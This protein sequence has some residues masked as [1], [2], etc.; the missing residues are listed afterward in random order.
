MTRR[1]GLTNDYVE[2]LCKKL[3]GSNYFL[4]VLP[5]DYLEKKSKLLFSK[6]EKNKAFAIIINL[7]PSYHSGSHFVTITYKNHHLILFDSFALPYQDPNIWT[8]IIIMFR[9]Y[10][11]EINS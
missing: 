5:C 8:F 9:E 1:L 7:S 4:G 2:T 10:K 6:V 11:K 3:T